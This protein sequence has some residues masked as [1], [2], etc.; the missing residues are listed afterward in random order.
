MRIL[1]VEDDALS[2]RMMAKVL[3]D[4]LGHDITECDS[5]EEAWEQFSKESYPW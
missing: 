2:R 5:A 4:F 1:L 3:E